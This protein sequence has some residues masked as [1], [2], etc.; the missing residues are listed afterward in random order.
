MLSA[1][2]VVPVSHALSCAALSQPLLLEA[3]LRSACDLCSSWARPQVVDVGT[4]TGAPKP[5][6]LAAL[7]ITDG[8]QPLA[9]DLGVPEA[10]ADSPVLP[11]PPIARDGVP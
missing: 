10:A 6:T 4:T 1:A 3:T 5:S 7:A 8:R 11:L 2:H 9:S